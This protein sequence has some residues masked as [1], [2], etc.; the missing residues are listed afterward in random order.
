MKIVL[1][2]GT[3][4]LGRVV[5]KKFLQ[6]KHSLNLIVRDKKKAEKLFRGLKGKI[7]FFEADFCDAGRQAGLVLRRACKGARVAV[8]AA[9]VV[10]ADGEKDFLK[11]NVGGTKRFLQACKLEKVKKFV[12]V[13]STAVYK[14]PLYVPIDEEHSFTPLNEYGK[15]KLAA[16]KAVRASGLDYF[17]LRPCLIYG[18][19]FSQGFKQVARAIEV[20]VMPVVGRGKNRIAL[21]HVDDAAGA[22]VLA[23]ESNVV[24]EDVII[25]GEALSQLECFKL[26]ARALKK[27]P[28]FVF[29]PKV[30][31]V[32]CVVAV[33]SAFKLFGVKSFLRADYVDVLGDDRF[34]SSK[35]ARRLLGYRAKKRFS[36]A[37]EG[38]NGWF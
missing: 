4:R 3:G 16:E 37:V 25:C 33:H 29:V 17:I 19:G 10:D 34:F 21:V 30:V 36:G 18:P 15:S 12:L 38:L 27:K 7:T 14:K 28:L 32:A 31:L 35:K 13:S 23:S 6:R 22:V 26:V 11:C 24:N 2:G 5:V 1:S 9:A 8:H 20:G